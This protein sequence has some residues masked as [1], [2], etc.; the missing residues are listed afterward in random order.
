MLGPPTRLFL[1]NVEPE[2]S[3]SLIPHVISLEVESIMVD[4]P[5]LEPA[6]PRSYG[7]QYT[8]DMPNTNP[9]NKYNPYPCREYFEIDRIRSA[10]PHSNTVANLYLQLMDNPELRHDQ[11]PFSVEQCLLTSSVMPLTLTINQSVYPGYLS[12]ANAHLEVQQSLVNCSH[13]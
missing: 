13:L 2:L 1:S 3:I 11:F 7:L 6:F 8:P 9:E 4:H 5:Q 12:L 10:H